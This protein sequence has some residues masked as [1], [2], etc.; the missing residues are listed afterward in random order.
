[1]R[2]DFQRQADAVV[3]TARRRADALLRAMVVEA[4][5]RLRDRTPVDTGH[6]RGNWN[7]AEG[8][9]D[10]TV[11]ARTQTGPSQARD[12]GDVRMGNVYYLTNAVPYIE[13]LEHGWSRQAP[14]GM[15]RVTAVELAPLAEQ[16]AVRIAA[17]V[18]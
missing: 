18:K 17:E 5:M 15:A 1:M 12:V 8:G 9:P 7:V 10:D 3:D 2:D 11:S 16:L 13:R 14:E 4:D 6:A